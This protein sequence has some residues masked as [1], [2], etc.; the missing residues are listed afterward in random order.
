[1]HVSIMEHTWFM[2]HGD[3]V[4]HEKSIPNVRITAAA[5]DLRAFVQKHADDDDL[6]TPS[7]KLLWRRE[8]QVLQ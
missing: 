2:N 7:V 8:K 5:K 1:M 6:W 3:A 4:A